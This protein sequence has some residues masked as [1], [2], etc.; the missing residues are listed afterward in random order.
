MNSKYSSQLPDLTQKE[1]PAYPARTTVLLSASGRIEEIVRLS[2]THYVTAAFWNGLKGNLSNTYEDQISISC[3]HADQRLETLRR[4]AVATKAVIEA[5]LHDE[6]AALGMNAQ[7]F[8]GHLTEEATKPVFVPAPCVIGV[9]KG[10]KY[11]P[12]I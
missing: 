3:Y 4:Q 1:H 9:D 10:V 5:L 7:A 8:F 12:D 11:G 6:A 2:G